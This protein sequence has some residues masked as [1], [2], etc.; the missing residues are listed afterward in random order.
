[1]PYGGIVLF[2]PGLGRIPWIHKNLLILH[3]IVEGDYLTREITKFVVYSS[4]SL[5]LV[6]AIESSFS[7]C[8]YKGTWVLAGGG[9]PSRRPGTVSGLGR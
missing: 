8:E 1:M 7:G 5:P 4:P 6:A 9:F 2:P 3:S